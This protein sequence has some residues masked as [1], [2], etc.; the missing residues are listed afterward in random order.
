MWKL[1]VFALYYVLCTS[2]TKQPTIKKC[3]GG[4]LSVKAHYVTVLYRAFVNDYTDAYLHDHTQESPINSL[5]N[6]IGIGSIGQ[7][8]DCWHWDQQGE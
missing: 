8:I 3:A 2:W 4:M 6:N 7:Y 1:L 5:A